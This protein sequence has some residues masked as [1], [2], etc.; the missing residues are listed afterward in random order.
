MSLGVQLRNDVITFASWRSPLVELD[1]TKLRPW[2]LG[3]IARDALGQYAPQCMVNQWLIDL[4]VPELLEEIEIL[5]PTPGPRQEMD[6]PLPIEDLILARA[7]TPV[8]ERNQQLRSPKGATDLEFVVEEA[9]LKSGPRV[10]EI[11]SRQT[12]VV[13]RLNRVAERIKIS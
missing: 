6:L 10:A 4:V 2:V 5:I 1:F 13:S 11:I 8:L 3:G 9:F 7:I 12:E